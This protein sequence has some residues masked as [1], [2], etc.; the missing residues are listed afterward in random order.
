MKILI[1]CSGKP[2]NPKWSF[3][4]TRSYVYEQIESIKKLGIEYDTYFI[5][6]K[7][8]LGY[9]KNYASMV[10]KIKSYQPDLIHAHFGLSGLLA[11]LYRKTPVITTFHGCDINVKKNRKFS[12]LASK[13]SVENIFVNETQPSKINY[14]KKI[15]II[16]CGIDMDIFVPIDKQ[17]ARKQ[18]NL[19]LNKKYALF[20]S[21]FETAVKN[22]PL[23]KEAIDKSENNIEVL[24]L[25]D[26][27]RE[28]VCLLLNAVDVLL[29][30]SFREGSPMIIKE[31]MSCNCPIVS[32]NVGD[33]KDVISKTENCYISSFNPIEISQYIDRVLNSNKETI[34]RDKVEEYSMDKI[35]D[36]IFKIYKRIINH[37][38]Q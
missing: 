10:K 27:T 21:S 5:E 17:L 18:L 28:E 7:G 22:Y 14:L 4:L 20:T 24:E 1:V 12:Y 8:V 11:S 9:L 3:E 29:M 19:S 34:G 6:G 30:T 26:Y 15:H 36:K 38:N 37:E 23:A 16:P 35:A 33:V 25:K 2:S 32:V 13:L 31:A